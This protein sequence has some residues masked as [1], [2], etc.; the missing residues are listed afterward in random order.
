MRKF[1]ALAVALLGLV[2][3]LLHRRFATCSAQVGNI[4]GTKGKNGRDTHLYAFCIVWL[5]ADL[6]RKSSPDVK[7]IG[8]A[9]GGLAAAAVESVSL[10]AIRVVLIAAFGWCAFQASAALFPFPLSANQRGLVSCLEKPSLYCDIYLP[11]AYSTNGPALP[12]LYTFNPG[13]GGMVSD[14]YSVCKQQNIICVGI[15]GPQNNNGW[16]VVFR[17]A[18]A[19]TRDIR[20]RVLFDPTAEFA[21]GFSGGGLVSYGFSRFR[22]Q[23]VAGVF[24]MSGWLGRGSGYPSYQTTDRV[25]TNLLVIRSM[26]L[27]DTGRFYN[28]APDSNYLASCGAVIHPDQWFAGGHEVPPDSV[29]STCLAWLISQ[30]VPSGPSDEANALGQGADWYARIAAGEKETVLRECVVALMSHPRSW[31]ALEAQLVLD[32]LMLDYDSFRPLAV[33]DLAQGDFASDLFYYL[34]RG[35]GDGSN[36]PRYRSALKALTGI[37][38]VNGDRAGDIRNLLLKYSYPAPLLRFTTDAAPSK[39][40]VLLSKDTPGLD[41][42][43]EG[44][45]NLITGSWQPLVLAVLDTNTVWSTDF[46]LPIGTQ[47]GFYRLRTTPSAG[48]SPPW[49]PQ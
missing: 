28:M 49:P 44:R 42:F 35:A 4:R 10:N 46:D 26:G 2:A 19:V 8:N 25:L 20:H 37:T 22:A 30:R 31:S 45:A 24:A 17:E 34:A 11:P 39:M 41:C 14:F 38:G 3:A 48:S 1:L 13:G 5:K 12:I 23:H 15:R 18:D 9:S 32:D 40:N 47:S 6:V 21:S 29:K 43:L 36:W 33:N 27:S 16:D 7:A